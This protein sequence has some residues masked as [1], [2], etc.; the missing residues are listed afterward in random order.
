MAKELHF[1]NHIFSPTKSF[2]M[3]NLLKISTML[4]ACLIMLNSCQDDFAEIPTQDE[5]ENVNTHDVLHR[6]CGVDKH[7]EKLMEDPAY[8]AD[9]ELRMKNFDK[10]NEGASSRAACSSPVVLPMAVHFQGISNPNASCLVALAQSQIDILNKDY[11]GSNGDISQWNSSASSYFPGVSNGEACI[12]FALGDKNHP[13]GFGLSDGQLAVTINKTTGDQANAWNGYINIFVQANT[14]LLGYSPL[15]GSGNGDGVVI[16]ANA[17]GAGSGCGSISPNA[18]FNLGRTLTHELGHYLLLDHIWGGGCGQDD[19]VSDTPNSADSHYDCPSLGTKTCNS[20]DMFMNYMDYVNDACMYM[21]SAGQASRMENY[22]NASL[23]NVISKGASVISG[24]TGGGNN[25]GG[26]TGG[27][28]G[29]DTDPEPDPVVCER[30]TQV[31]ATVLS[32][33]SVKITL[34]EQD[35]AVQYRLKYRRVGTSS[36]RY[37]NFN[38]PPYTLTGLGAG[39]SY[40]YQVRAQCPQGWTNFSKRQRFKTTVV[41]TNPNPTGCTKNAVTLKLILDEYG[42]ETTWE[43][44]KSSN[45]QIVAEGGPYQDGQS[46][47]KIEKDLCIADGC[48][49]LY[50]D[51]SYGDGI[52]CSYGDGSLEL[53]DA[54]GFVIGESNGNFGTYDYI[55]FCVENNVFSYKGNRTDL[56]IKSNDGSKV[57][58]N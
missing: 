33:T 57:K 31:N 17:F 20:N 48:Y 3:K 25:G 29:G 38:T 56:N 43:L 51:D 58:M 32:G 4:F 44:E 26:T 54:N 37:R 46:G 2:E 41:T 9:Y 53:L 30:P 23:Q 36:W 12:Q 18:P 8:R 7:M 13:A 15:G 16:D 14:G 35:G 27:N 55:D 10:L 19:G 24:N 1:S 21:F 45:G 42:S 34:P 28:N 11:S 39:K 40:D 47:K 5:I 22:V 6:N 49:T 50:I 52:C